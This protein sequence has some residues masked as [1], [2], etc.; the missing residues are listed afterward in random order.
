MR[1]EYA[2]VNFYGKMLF[3]QE[4]NAFN[5]QLISSAYT[6]WLTTNTKKKQFNDYLK[7]L[8][9]AEKPDK[10]SEDQKQTLQ[11]RADELAERILKAD[12]K[13]KTC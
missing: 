4:S 13:R 10:L 6:A 1:L 9:L 2:E 8:G 3:E 5:N 11:K 7:M 12:N